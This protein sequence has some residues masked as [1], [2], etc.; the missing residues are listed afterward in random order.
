MSSGAFG[1][2][3][4]FAALIAAIGLVVLPHSEAPVASADERAAYSEIITLNNRKDFPA[5]REKCER[6]MRR[7][8]N[9]KGYE[10]VATLA[11]EM[12]VW[13][14]D[15][16]EAG[17]AYRELEKKFPRSKNLDRFVFFQGLAAFQEADFKLAI[18]QYERFLKD[19]PNS[20]LV[21]NA[22]YYV[23]MSYFLSNKYKETLAACG[24]YLMK[25]PDGRYAGDMRYRLSF[26]D[27]NDKE[28]DQSDKIIRDLSGFL[29]EHPDDAANGSMY[30][31]LADTY[32]KKEGKTDAE[33]KSYEDKAIE[34]YIKAVWTDSPDDVIEYA[35]ESATNMLRTRKDWRAVA[36]LHAE[37]LKRKPRSQ[38]AIDWVDEEARAGDRNGKRKISRDI[39]TGVLKSDIANPASEHVE[40]LINMFVMSLVP[41]RKLSEINLDELDKQLVGILDEVAAG[42]ENL[43]TK[44]RIE[45]ARARLALILKN[46]ERADHFLKVLATA[47]A[48][49]P[50]A[51]SPALLET[52]GGILLK[53]G[54]PDGAEA[55]FKRLRDLFSKTTFG[56]AGAVGLGNVALVR[57]K[58]DTALGIFEESLKKPDNTRLKEATLG[59]LQTLVDLNQLAAAEKLA[60]EIVG[61]K[62][63]CGESAAKAYLQLAWIYR[64]QAAKAEGAKARELLKKAHSIYIRVF[65]SYKSL[66]D[67][68]AEGMWE[69]AGTAGEMGDEELRRK[70]LKDL[71]DDPKLEGTEPYRKAA[72]QAK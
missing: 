70:N 2:P 27:F 14:G 45:Y 16:K 39:L 42:Q 32:K 18:P 67:L 20:A 7:Y 55:M 43:T 61:D 53:A 48:R 37:F 15:W 34:A 13:S 30:C 36:Y 22:H 62:Q 31:L 68:S 6:F 24:E 19:F 23:A 44:A 33:L 10:A 25:F 56:D 4:C 29:A 51:L 40:D 38:V 64:K 58:P 54:D 52:C 60:E 72:K 8:P 50:S 28:V 9:S 12:M 65:V 26:I 17:S 11:G 71:L 57:K 59:K 5:L 35:L 41:R 63:F 21:E 1:Y 66:P 47:F 3:L 46:N 69:A 49:D